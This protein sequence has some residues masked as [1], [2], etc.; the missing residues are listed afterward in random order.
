MHRRCNALSV[1]AQPRLPPRLVRQRRPLRAWQELQARQV[2]AELLEHQSPYSAPKAQLA[3]Q[4]VAQAE[5]ARRRAGLPGYQ[6]WETSGPEAGRAPATRCQEQ[7]PARRHR[8]LAASLRPLRHDTTGAIDGPIRFAFVPRVNL[9]R[10]ASRKATT[11]QLFVRTRRLA[12]P[13][14]PR[15]ARS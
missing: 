9:A 7:S 3:R 14:Q 8:P 4:V 2:L 13:R 10:R 15:S 1:R 11:T 12:P 6:P 5:P